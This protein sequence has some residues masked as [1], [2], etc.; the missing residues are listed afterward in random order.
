MT[1]YSC[2][3]PLWLRDAWGLEF[4]D[5]DYA[6]LEARQFAALRTISTFEELIEPADEKDEVSVLAEMLVTK[7]PNEALAEWVAKTTG[8]RHRRTF[9]SRWNALRLSLGDR[10]RP[11]PPQP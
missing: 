4:A 10:T 1:D 6:R 2:N 3:E 7:V 11:Q 8:M 9:R 5:F